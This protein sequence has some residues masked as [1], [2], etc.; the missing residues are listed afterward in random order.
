MVQC[1]YGIGV[2]RSFTEAQMKEYGIN[3]NTGLRL[4]RAQFA[5]LNDMAKTLNVSRN[6]MVALLIDGAEVES[7]PVL[8]VGLG[9]NA[10][11]AIA[12]EDR[13]A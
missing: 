8:S 11:R 6:K 10:S 1:S 2:F 13:A 3:I 5:K 12:H 4:P 9:K 7:K